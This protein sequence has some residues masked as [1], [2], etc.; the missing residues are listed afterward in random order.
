MSNAWQELQEAKMSTKSSLSTKSSFL[1][2]VIFLLTVIL[3][4]GCNRTEPRVIEGEEKLLP[5]NQDIL[6]SC[7]ETN[8]LLKETIENTQTYYYQEKNYQEKIA[9]Q[10]DLIDKLLENQ[11]AEIQVIQEEEIYF[12]NR[13][14]DWSDYLTDFWLYDKSL[15]DKNFN[16]ICK[17]FLGYR[18]E[19][20]RNTVK[21]DSDFGEDFAIINEK[22]Q[23]DR[24]VSITFVCKRIKEQKVIINN[25][26]P[27]E[28]PKDTKCNKITL[29]DKARWSCG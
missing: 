24:N 16:T 6:D 5:T 20:N 26:C 12:V 7:S 22:G 17:E 23:P 9:E 1:F 4:S 14:I 13:T 2:G 28:C 11:N 27:Y 21:I 10:K 29:G 3:I 25:E 19:T 8:R 18:I 15:S